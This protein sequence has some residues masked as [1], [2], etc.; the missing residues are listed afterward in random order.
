MIEIVCLC[1]SVSLE[2]NV[3]VLS[4]FMEW[5][6]ALDWLRRQ[7]LSTNQLELRVC[8]C[9]CVHS[10]SQVDSTRLTRRRRKISSSSSPKFS[11]RNSKGGVGGGN[12]TSRY[13]TKE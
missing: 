7:V 2:L 8:V 3:F 6:M 10:P 1:A 13:D 4:S 11:T 9:V 5:L 12:Q